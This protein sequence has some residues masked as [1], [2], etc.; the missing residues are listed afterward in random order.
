MV[1]RGAATPPMKTIT[2][3]DYLVQNPDSKKIQKR[4]ARAIKTYRHAARDLSHAS[5]DVAHAK[6]DCLHAMQMF[7]VALEDCQQGF[8]DWAKADEEE[9][10][11]GSE[12]TPADAP[13]DS[14]PLDLDGEVYEVEDDE[15]DDEG[16]EDDEDNLEEHPANQGDNHL[17][18]AA[19]DFSAAIEDAESVLEELC[20]VE[21]LLIDILEIAAEEGLHIDL[22][23]A[24][25]YV[26]AKAA[27]PAPG[28]PSTTAS[29]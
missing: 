8:A 22:T 10:H 16:D 12:E 7:D 18:H 29:A 4:L 19:K 5:E 24:K 27:E 23:D 20:K 9:I 15:V 14:D 26:V 1:E 17:R 25:A 13:E 28:H 2:L 21:N 11:L 3:S 6:E